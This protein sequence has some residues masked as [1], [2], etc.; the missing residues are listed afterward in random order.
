[1][2]HVFKICP[3][4]SLTQLCTKGSS[5][6][7]QRSRWSC[8]QEFAFVPLRVLSVNYGSASWPAHTLTHC[9]GLLLQILRS[10]FVGLLKSQTPETLLFAFMSGRDFGPLTLA[11]HGTRHRSAGIA[12]YTH[13]PMLP[14]PQAWSMELAFEESRYPNMRYASTVGVAVRRLLRSTSS[15]ASR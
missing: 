7:T 9:C 2:A 13:W 4:T 14:L 6:S 10:R 11:I 15:L 1:M 8:P 5:A 12:T 3:Q